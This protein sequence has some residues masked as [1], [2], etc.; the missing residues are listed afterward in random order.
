MSSTDAALTL[1][2]PVAGSPLQATCEPG[3]TPFCV[4]CGYNLSGL[5]SQRC[6]ECG[7]QIDWDLAYADPDAHRPGT[8]AHRASGWHVIDLTLLTLLMMLVAPWRFAR[9]LR[10]DESIWPSILVAV[11]AFAIW[12]LPAIIGDSDPLRDVIPFM[13][14]IV[15]VVVLQVSVFSLAHLE[16]TRTRSAW[17][18]RLRVWLIVSFYSSCFIAAWTVVE[19]PIASFDEPN[20]YVPWSTGS[21]GTFTLSPNIGTTIIFYWWWLILATVL[22]VRNRPRWLVY[23]FAIAGRI[24][25]EQ[26]DRLVPRQLF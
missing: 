10:A 15:A 12:F 23:L 26:T 24:V 1:S 4:T 22:V 11:V 21:Y 3:A 7:W 13:A 9:D 2:A 16:H 5:T 17:R 6:P 25:F 18:Q 19:L 14:A 8:P 20:F